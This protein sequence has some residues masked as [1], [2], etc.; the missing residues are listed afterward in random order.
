MRQRLLISTLLLLLSLAASAQISPLSDQYLLN[1]FVVNPAVAGSERYAP[2][3]LNIRQQWAGWDGAPTIQSISYHKRLRSKG[4]FYTPQGFRNKGKNSYGKL[5]VGGGLFNYNYGAVSHTGIHAVYSY[6]VM[7]NNGR[8]ALG[9][10]PLFFQ[11]RINKI[12]LVAPDPAIPDPLLQDPSES[13]WF[14]DANVGFHYYTDRFYAGASVLQLLNGSVK[15]GDYSFNK[16]DDGILSP[17]LA[18]TIYV[19]TGYAWEMT[20]DLVLEPSLYLRYNARSGTGIH[21]NA[22][23][24]IRDQFEAGLGYRL[25]EGAL[26]LAGATLDNLTLTYQFELPIGNNIPNRFTNHSVGVRLKLGEPVD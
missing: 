5:G 2:L 14:L 11:Y 1:R 16:L 10:A 15:F 13:L 20:R 8:L 25:G 24:R 26:L 3:N 6:H 4:L 23:F 18:S 19:Y 12:G 21:V 22:L 7:L 17:D 9:L